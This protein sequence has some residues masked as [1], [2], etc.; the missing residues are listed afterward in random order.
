MSFSIILLLKFEDNHIGLWGEEKSDHVQLPLDPSCWAG[1]LFRVPVKE[2]IELLEL[3]IKETYLSFEFPNLPEI[4]AILLMGTML[5]KE[6]VG[7]GIGMGGSEI[8][9]ELLPCM[10]GK[11]ITVMVNN[12]AVLSLENLDTHGPEGTGSF[13]FFHRIWVMADEG[14]RRFVPQEY[15]T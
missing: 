9:G 6:R 5:K 15:W 13:L 4:R 11:E 14:I 1:L 10:M 12:Y 3:G 2:M 8:G 7:L